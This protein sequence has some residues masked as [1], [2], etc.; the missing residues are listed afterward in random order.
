MNTKS[1][2][3]I[4]QESCSRPWWHPVEIARR[5][6]YL[7]MRTAI[8]ATIHHTFTK[9]DFIEVQTPS[10]QMSPGL[11]PHLMAFITSWHG[12]LA[13]DEFRL[14]LHLSPEL[15]M[16]KLIAGGL[17]RQFQ[18]CKVFRNGDRTCIHHPEFTLLE[19][20]RAPA[21]YSDLIADVQAIVR[22]AATTAKID[23]LSF[24]N[25]R[26]DP[27][28][29]WQI[30]TVQD[31][32]LQF[33]DID[34][35]ATTPNPEQP[36]HELLALQAERIGMSRHD[37]DRWEDL[38]MRIL[39][40]RIEPN[41]GIGVPTILIDYPICLAMM[42]RA[43]PNQPQ[44]AERLEI[45]VCG[46]E[47]ANGYGELIDAD[48]QR[49]RFETD[50]ALKRSLYNTDYPIDEDFLAALTFGLPDC[51]GMALGFDRL[52]MLCSGACHIE[53]VLWAPVILSKGSP[54]SMK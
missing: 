46:I 45:Y 47:L 24:D 39:V 50:V 36:N 8:T 48:Q 14:Y 25:K 54:S 18:L 21:Q 32:F 27:F 22:A 17:Q 4:S 34:L 43:K 30:L 9:L 19:W 3:S 1:L 44:I 41:L 49:A 23:Y 42:A 20:Y 51:A 5:R 31:A 35:L 11:E 6:P 40:D 26:C 2:P 52:V 16:K 28:A 13:D 29:H 38:F 37:G 10:L 12:A 53:D 7:D 33:A 15:A